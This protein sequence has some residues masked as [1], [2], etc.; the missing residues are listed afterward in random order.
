MK[1]IDHIVMSEKFIAQFKRI[2]IL[3]L[4]WIKTIDHKGIVVELIISA[5]LCNIA[6]NKFH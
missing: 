3:N 5:N 6:G 4:I 2:K 1:H